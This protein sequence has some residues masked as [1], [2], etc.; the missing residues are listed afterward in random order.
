MRKFSRSCNSP[1]FTTY[2]DAS[3]SPN[4]ELSNHRFLRCSS[5][6]KWSRER[7]SVFSSETIPPRVIFQTHDCVFSFSFF[8]PP[9]FFLRFQRR[10]IERRFFSISRRVRAISSAPHHK[11]TSRGTACPS[12]E[13]RSPLLLR[14]RGQSILPRLSRR[15]SRFCHAYTIPYAPLCQ[16]HLSFT[17][18]VVSPSSGCHPAVSSPECRFAISNS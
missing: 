18:S 4:D 8:F 17:V 7:A 2:R 14:F 12:R 10:T 5:I 3:C 6:L 11:V 15:T 1:Q 13:N 9:F 16:P